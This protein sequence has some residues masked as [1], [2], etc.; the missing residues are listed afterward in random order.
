MTKT[1]KELKKL[2][3]SVNGKTPK[4]DHTWDIIKSIAKDYTGGG[5][6]GADQQER[7]SFAYNLVVNSNGAQFG[8]EHGGYKWET[9]EDHPWG[10]Y[11]V[12]MFYKR[13]EPVTDMSVIKEYLKFMTGSDF[14]PEYNATEPHDTFIYLAS[15]DYTNDDRVWKYQYVEQFGLLVFKVENFPFVLKGEIPESF[16]RISF[17]YNFVVNSNGSVYQGVKMEDATDPTGGGYTVKILRDSNSDEAIYDRDRIGEYLEHMTGSSYIPEYNADKSTDTFIYLSSNDYSDPDRVWKYQLTYNSN[18]N[19]YY[20]YAFK[21]NNFP[22]ALK[23]EIP[24]PG[25]VS[26][27]ATGN[28]DPNTEEVT[29]EFSDNDYIKNANSLLVS[30]LALGDNSKQIL[31]YWSKVSNLQGESYCS[32]DISTEYFSTYTVIPSVGFA[33]F[34]ISGITNYVG[35]TIRITC[36]K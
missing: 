12:K 21:V 15:S 16:V 36:F 11:T 22:F 32:F 23:S 5:G 29:F 10:G 19:R 34:I 31:Q 3:A 17:A 1:N 7:I 14:V 2:G 13:E 24:E 8:G 18:A 9:I 4:G 33:K 28:Y 30:A 35:S 26:F 25:V 20:L 6:G 27:E